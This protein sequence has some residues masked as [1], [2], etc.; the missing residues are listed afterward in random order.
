MPLILAPSSRN[1]TA[2]FSDSDYIMRSLNRPKREIDKE[3]LA[4]SKANGCRPE[5]HQTKYS[6]KEKHRFG[7]STK[8]RWPPGG[9][10]AVFQAS[11][12]R[13]SLVS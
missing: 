2:R 10:P 4:K 5:L 9:P 13:L 8:H 3:F 1:A 11:C 12:P 7:L 6:I